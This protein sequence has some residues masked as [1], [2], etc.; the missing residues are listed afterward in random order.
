MLPPLRQ[1]AEWLMAPQ[2]M[3]V[4][5]YLLLVLQPAQLHPVVPGAHPGTGTTTSDLVP[6]IMVKRMQ[7]RWMMLR[8]DHCRAVR[9]AH[10]QAAQPQLI[11]P[12]AQNGAR[13]RRVGGS[14]SPEP[15]QR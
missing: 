13:S 2:M 11:R 1:G 8:K 9:K 4:A 14:G 7:S 15:L 12:Q 10:Q 6:V 3:I 5:H